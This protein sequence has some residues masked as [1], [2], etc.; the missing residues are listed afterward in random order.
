MVTFE[1]I[2]NLVVVMLCGTSNSSQRIAPSQIHF[3]WHS[4]AL[5]GYKNQS[6]KTSK[7]VIDRSLISSPP[8]GVNDK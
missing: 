1:F 2:L 7:V 5:H 4:L 8:L 6:I 3:L